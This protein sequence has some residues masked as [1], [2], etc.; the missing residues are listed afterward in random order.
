MILTLI[1]MWFIS[2]RRWKIEILDPSSYEHTLGVKSHAMYTWASQDI[3]Q[4][5]IQAFR[6]LLFIIKRLW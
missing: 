1:A 3:A 6:C 4:R 5:L 2:S